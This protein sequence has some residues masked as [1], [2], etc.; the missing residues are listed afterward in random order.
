[1]H[2]IWVLLGRAL[3]KAVLAQALV[4]R[5]DETRRVVSFKRMAL[6]DLKVEI[7]RLAKKKVLKEALDSSGNWNC[8]QDAQ[9]DVS[10][11]CKAARLNS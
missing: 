6:T 10:R 7:P 11:L 9:Q 4:D 1:L 5:P 8:L 3:S 2:N